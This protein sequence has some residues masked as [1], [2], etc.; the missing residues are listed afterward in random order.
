MVSYM[1]NKNKL[2]DFKYKMGLKFIETTYRN[3]NK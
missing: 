2:G 3:K 1:E